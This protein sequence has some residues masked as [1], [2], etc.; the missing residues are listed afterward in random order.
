MIQKL[1]LYPPLAIS[2][3][4]PSPTPCDNF[5]WGPND[6][7][8]RGTGKTTIVP[9]DTLRVSDDGTVS[10]FLPTTLTFKDEIGWKP[11]CPFFEVHGLV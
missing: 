9:V 2:R 8:P 6:L 3:V 5:N 7:T 1:V 4:G 11:V 10:S